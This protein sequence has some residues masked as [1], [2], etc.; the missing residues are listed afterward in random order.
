LWQI[1][2]LA[3]AGTWTTLAFPFSDMVLTKRG[4]IEMQQHPVERE[5][6]QG[7]RA[8]RRL[9]AHASSPLASVPRLLLPTAPLPFRSPA[10]PAPRPSRVAHLP[11]QWGVLL[12]DGCNGPF[13]F[14]IQYL[15]AV[16]ELVAEEHASA[17]E[18]VVASGG[19]RGAAAAAAAAAAQA[20]VAGGSARVATAAPGPQDM[21]R[22][23]L[24]A[25]YREQRERARLK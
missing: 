4:R 6:I 3:P 21:S 13:S 7:V 10:R 18:Q 19:A 25:Y 23:D 8:Q 2:L 9:A 24:R 12:A 1:R 22:D 14:E 20:A 11:P 5:H 16:R 15:R 17:A